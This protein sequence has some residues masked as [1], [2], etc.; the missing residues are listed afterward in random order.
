MDVNFLFVSALNGVVYGAFL[1]LTSLGL[2]LVFGL[3]RV[4]NFAHGALY[5][6]G[7][8][9]L[10]EVARRAGLGY[11]GALVAAPLVVVPLAIVIERLTIFPVRNRPEIYRLLVT[12]GVS[13]MIIG[14]LEGPWGTGTALITTPRPFGGTV[15]LA[16]QPV[17]RVPTGR[18]GAVADRLGG[19]VRLRAA[20]AGRPPDSRHHGRRDM[21]EALGIDAK[22]ILTL[23]FGGAAGLAA[24]AGALGV[25]SSRCI[26]RWARESCWTPS[27]R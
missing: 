27:W 2:S 13:L 24:F 16:R 3:G 22:R 17:S 26:R 23:V 19:G 21:A 9:A 11:W 5:A 20:H 10:A 25:R 1:L 12:F 18:R 6:L 14:G 15:S 8:Y 7:G 4:V